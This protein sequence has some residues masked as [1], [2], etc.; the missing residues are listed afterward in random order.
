M[1]K[2]YHF[3]SKEFLRDLQTQEVIEAGIPDKSGSLRYG[4]DY[5]FQTKQ[6]NGG[7]GM[8]FLWETLERKGTVDYCEEEDASF[9]LLELAIPRQEALDTN[10]DE[11]CNLCSVLDEAD[12]D[13]ILADDYCHDYIN[14]G[15]DQAY[16]LLFDLGD[17]CL[18]QTLVPRLN[19]A[20]ITAIHYTKNKFV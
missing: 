1:I 3:C 9:V 2:R 18:I 13:L 8:F 16:E 19:Q 5:V 15:L 14:G 17:D 4:Y 20:W 6:L 10:Y 12:G 7:N 11:W